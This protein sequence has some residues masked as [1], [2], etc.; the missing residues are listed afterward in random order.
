MQA[1]GTGRHRTLGVLHARTQG[2][3]A[4]QFDGIDTQA[5]GD[6]V[7]HHLGRRHALQGAV[8]THRPGFHRA[9]MVGGDLQVVLRHVVDRLRCGGA[10]RRHRWAVVD[11]TTAVDAHLGAENLEAVIGL[12]HR[13]LIADV[14][15]MALDAALE[16]LVAVVG[17][18]HR[19][20]R[21]IQRGKGR[22]VNENIVVL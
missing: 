6:F 5:I 22:V 4:A 10:N 8:A 11:P 2:V 18:A 13:Q 7:D 3:L 1:Q 14:E 16:L 17:Q 15:R 12:V 19:H 21:A 20:T 9:G